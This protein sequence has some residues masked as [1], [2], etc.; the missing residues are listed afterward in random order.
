[1]QNLFK[2]EKPIKSESGTTFRLTGFI[3]PARHL[4]E[5]TYVQTDKMAN[6][7]SV[8]VHKENPDITLEYLRDSWAVRNAEQRAVNI[9]FSTDETKEC[10][11]RV[12]TA[13]KGEPDTAPVSLWDECGP[14][15][16]ITACTSNLFR[17]NHFL[18]L[19]PFTRTSLLYL[20]PY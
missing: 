17:H 9:A 4:I 15:T 11:A 13:G 14:G 20:T 12:K 18:Y 6:N 1:M 16:T 19:N 10:F 8:F 2:V 7:C 5:G 3:G